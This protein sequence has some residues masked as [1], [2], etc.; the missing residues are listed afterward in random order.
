MFIS[1]KIK[2]DLAAEQ[3]V[4]DA[5]DMAET[6]FDALADDDDFEKQ[7]RLTLL[8]RGTSPKEISSAVQYIL[9]APAMTGQ[10]IVLD[11][12]QHLVWQTPDIMEV[13]E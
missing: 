3:A 5:F 13:D 1:D 4:E 2:D 11:G 6:V 7:K 12:G 10:M 8:K 9:T